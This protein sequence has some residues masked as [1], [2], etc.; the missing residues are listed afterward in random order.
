[1]LPNRGQAPFESQLKIIVHRCLVACKQNV[2]F[3]GSWR[4]W[5][6]NHTGTIWVYQV[7]CADAAQ[8]MDCRLLIAGALN[9]VYNVVYAAN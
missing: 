4:G 9:M 8:C 5:V 1:M 7:V 2:V 6:S 3:F